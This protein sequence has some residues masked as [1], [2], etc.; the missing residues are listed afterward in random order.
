MSTLPSASVDALVVGGGFFGVSVAMYLRQRGLRVHLLEREGGPMLR[1][2]LRNQARVH[3]G[4]HYPRS[5]STAAAARDAA[6]LFEE[7]F[8]E[9]V[10]RA[11][12]YYAIAPGSLTSPD[13][14]LAFC[15][16]L[17]LPYEV[18]DKPAQLHT[19]DLCVKV[20]EGLF[21]FV[22][23]DSDNRPRAIEQA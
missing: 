16:R 9:A 7:R 10:R 4:Y 1:A 22:A 14:Y 18:V 21:T 15:D 2:S 8:P 17:G 5:D 19:A 13:E 11:Q 12:H 23:L 20:T 6:G 3:A